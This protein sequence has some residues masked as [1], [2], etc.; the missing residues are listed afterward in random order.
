MLGKTLISK[1]S[2]LLNNNQKLSMETGLWW[3]KHKIKTYIQKNSTLRK[4]NIIIPFMWLTVLMLVMIHIQESFNKVYQWHAQKIHTVESCYK[5][6]CE[7][8]I[9]YKYQLIQST[10]SQVST[11]VCCVIKKVWIMKAQEYFDK[12]CVHVHAV[13]DTSYHENKTSHR[14]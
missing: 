5:F 12:Y 4:I 9:I 2:K 1:A 7:H 6:C 8:S 11:S 3:Y 14:T 10:V 13:S